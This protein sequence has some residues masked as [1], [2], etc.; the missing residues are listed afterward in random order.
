M[1]LDDFQPAVDDAIEGASATT[2][3]AAD[4]ADLSL[5]FTPIEEGEEHQDEANSVDPHFWLDPIRLAAV[6]AALA[7]SL[8]AQDPPTRPPTATTPGTCVRPGRPRCRVRRHA[9]LVC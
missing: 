1:Y 6:G 8:S 2:F 5:T 9:G 3:D 7:D 4:S